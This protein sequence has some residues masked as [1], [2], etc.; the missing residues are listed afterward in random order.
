MATAVQQDI[1]RVLAVVIDRAHAR[2]FE[3]TA[4]DVTELPSFQSPAMRGGKFHSDRQGGP[5]WGEHAYHGRIREEERRHVDGVVQCLLHLDHE[6]PADG[7]LVAGIGGA[8]AAL[9]LALPP[10]LAD[11]LVGTTRLNPTEVT[12]AKV[13][14][15]ARRAQQTREPAVESELVAALKEGLGTGLATNGARETLRALAKSQVRTLLVAADVQATGFRCARSQRL[16]LSATDC[17][18]DGEPIPVP[19]L[20]GETTALAR[21]QSATVVTIRDP[22][23]VRH[24]DGIA[25]L[26]RFP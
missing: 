23:A 1:G 21:R 2:F 12:A 11:R 25:A 18:E 16:V 3:V 22:E 14:R 20:I 4:A 24:I 19:D 6:R 9:A 13:A 17:L 5:G 7:L 10:V 8:V 15:A 26:L